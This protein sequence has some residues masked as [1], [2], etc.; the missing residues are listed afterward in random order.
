MSIRPSS[1]GNADQLFDKLIGICNERDNGLGLLL[2]EARA[3]P[4]ALID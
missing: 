3:Q 2:V 1:V 4:P